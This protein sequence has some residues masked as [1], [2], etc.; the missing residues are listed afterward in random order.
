MKIAGYINYGYRPPAPFVTASI[1]LKA[2]CY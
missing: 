1:L 2:V